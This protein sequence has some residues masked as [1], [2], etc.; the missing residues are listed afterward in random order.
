MKRLRWFVWVTLGCFCW[1]GCG[2]A[3]RL[4]GCADVLECNEQ[5]SDCPFGPSFLIDGYATLSEQGGYEITVSYGH[6]H[7]S[8][9]S[10]EIL[11]RVQIWFRLDGPEYVLDK[12]SPSEYFSETDSG[13]EYFDKVDIDYGG[14]HTWEW[15]GSYHSDEA[16]FRFPAV[17]VCVAFEA[18]WTSDPVEE[19]LTQ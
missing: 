14:N 16:V 10:N 19:E 3:S 17:E 9:Y 4:S 6:L 1:S 8:N 18:H 2:E 13:L 12:W 5:M 7:V 15:S 11:K